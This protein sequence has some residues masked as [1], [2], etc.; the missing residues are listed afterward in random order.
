M[1]TVSQSVFLDDRHEEK[2]AA[3]IV[4][5]MSQEMRRLAAVVEDLQTLIGNLVVAGGFS[6]SSS[7]VQ[8]QQLDLLR[9][10]LSGL[11]DFSNSMSAI[12]PVDWKINARHA[13][14]NLTL[15]DLSRRL[16]SSPINHLVDRSIHND[17]ELF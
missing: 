5:V 7:V 11:S 3:Q 8:L 1:S 16:V 12:M 17:L 6:S 9:Q 13:V 10:E 4:A 15:V 14:Q 2:S